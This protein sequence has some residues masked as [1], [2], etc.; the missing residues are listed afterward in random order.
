MAF[1]PEIGLKKDII[2][3]LHRLPR[4]LIQLMNRM[5]MAE[6]KDTGNALWA[7]PSLHFPGDVLHSGNPL[8]LSDNYHDTSGTKVEN[9]SLTLVCKIIHSSSLL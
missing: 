3:N 6:A 9:G 5:S 4:I 8:G 2:I 7:S 1:S